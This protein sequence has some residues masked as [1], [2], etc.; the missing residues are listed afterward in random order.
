MV[1][2]SFSPL[3]FFFLF[4][5]WY[6]HTFNIPPPADSPPDHASLDRRTPHSFYL[7]VCNFV[8]FS[9]LR[10]H[11]YTPTMQSYIGHVQFTKKNSLEFTYSLTA[12][13]APRRPRG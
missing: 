10:L 7:L 8:A 6:I 9:Y 2:G 1:L 11:D 13:S 4:L 3:F 5:F 12:H